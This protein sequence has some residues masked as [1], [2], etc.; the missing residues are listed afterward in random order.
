MDKLDQARKSEQHYVL[1]SLCIEN[2]SYIF[3]LRSGKGTQIGEEC[4][5]TSES[6]QNASKLFPAVSAIA[7][8][9]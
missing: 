2:N 7:D 5:D 8:K 9:P 6:K 3:F 4:F 1:V